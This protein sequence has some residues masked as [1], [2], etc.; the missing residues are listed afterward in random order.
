MQQLK[1]ILRLVRWQNLL[2]TLFVMILMEKMVAV[3]ILLRAY[4]PEVVPQYVFV[5]LLLSVVFIQA[6]GYAINDYFDVKIDAINRPDRLIVTRTLTKP[7]V[8]LLHQVL[9]CIGIAAGVVVAIVVRSWLL[10]III[11]FVPGLLWFYSSSYKR[12]FIIGNIIVSVASALSVLVVAMVNTAWLESHFTD[13]AGY[14][15]LA[16]SPLVHDLYTAIGLFSLFAFLTT[17]IREVEK[18]LQDQNG[19]R[20]MECHTMPIR[21]GETRTKVFVSLLIA[22]TAALLCYVNFGLTP[23]PHGWGTVTTHYLTFGLLVPLA[24]NLYMLWTA[25]ISSDY[26]N[27]Q[28]L[29]KFIMLVGVMYSLVFAGAMHAM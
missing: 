6:G 20:E 15:A 2:M 23:Y 11:F 9:T 12:Q 27:A 29:T 4:Y 17:W 16:D 1:D 8:M 3:P 13:I 24:C 22:L 21:I 7:Q 28:M 5:L 26:R 19:D 25:K 10:G 18:D 14:N